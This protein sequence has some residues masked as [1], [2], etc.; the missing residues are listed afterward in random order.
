M[1][2]LSG[3]L[4]YSGRDYTEEEFE[5][6]R[7]NVSE[8]RK[9]DPFIRLLLKASWEDARGI[10]NA[11]REMEG[12][13]GDEVFMKYYERHCACQGKLILPEKAFYDVEV[14]DVWEMT[15]KTVL[16]Q[17]NGEVQIPL[18]GKEGIAVM[19]RKCV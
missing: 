15:K 16:E 3:P 11:N 7:K 14:I 9:K 12:N 19:A 5:E 17:V 6:L 10:L 13:C 4:T 1:E 2:S 18:P 8:E